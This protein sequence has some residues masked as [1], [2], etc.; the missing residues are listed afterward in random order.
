MFI[1][2]SPVVREKMKGVDG[3]SEGEERN[4]MLIKDDKRV[5]EEKKE[6]EMFYFLHPNTNMSDTRGEDGNVYGKGESMTK[7]IMVFNNKNVVTVFVNN[8]P[9]VKEDNERLVKLIQ[10]ALKELEGKRK[11]MEK[12]LMLIILIVVVGIYKYRNIRKLKWIFYLLLKRRHINN[13]LTSIII[14]GY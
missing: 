9:G 14:E 1:A 5:I 2:V 6:E 12:G 4:V 11:Q 13:K 8:W 3:V 10:C 7:R